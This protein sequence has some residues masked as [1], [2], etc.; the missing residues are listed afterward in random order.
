MPDLPSINEE[1]LPVL[2]P[3]L[4]FLYSL[5]TLL[6]TTALLIVSMLQ[7]RSRLTELVTRDQLLGVFA[8]T[9][10]KRL[11]PRIV[12]PAASEGATAIWS[13]YRLRR[14]RRQILRFYRNRLMRLQFF[15][16]VGGLLA[17]AA[18]GGA[19]DYLHITQIEITISARPAFVAALALV[20]VLLFVTFGQMA[21]DA[22][23][24]A[25]LGRISELPFMSASASTLLLPTQG[26][27]VG[28]GSVSG[29]VASPVGAIAPILDSI[30]RLMETIERGRNSL[31]VPMLQ[32]SASA[33]AL[34]SM[35]KALSERPVDT[36]QAGTEFRTAIDRLTAKIEQLAARPA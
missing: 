9:G 17:I 21:V 14:A 2:I 36:V 23:G 32:L 30:E 4:I 11:G 16:G 10:L 8:Q 22:A 7:A 28:T 3:G 15:T 25:L 5:T 20:L 18:L 29:S 33:E 35:A 6:I 1:L 24:R 12:D 31:R 27:R 26:E 13:P 19:Q 34:A